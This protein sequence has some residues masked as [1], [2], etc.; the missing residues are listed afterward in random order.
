MDQELNTLEID[1]DI[2]YEIYES[3]DTFSYTKFI[4]YIRSFGEKCKP[5]FIKKHKNIH[6]DEIYALDPRFME[7]KYEY[8]Y[9]YDEIMVKISWYDDII[10]PNGEVILKYCK[11]IDKNKLENLRRKLINSFCC[12]FEE[13]K[14]YDDYIKKYGINYY[15]PKI[16]V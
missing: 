12:P 2:L 3:S 6:V 15:T 4:N 10:F 13:T 9:V 5:E 7:G 1:K 14:T 11:D 16:K 8:K